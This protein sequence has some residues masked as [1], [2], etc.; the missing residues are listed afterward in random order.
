MMARTISSIL[1]LMGILVGVP[2]TGQDD[3][4]TAN[5]YARWENGPSAGDD[6]FPIAVWL[7]NP[8]NASRYRQ[9]GINLYIESPDG[10]NVMLTLRGSDASN[11]VELVGV[12][13]KMEVRDGKLGLHLE[14]YGFQLLRFPLR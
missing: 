2:A 5:G 4:A 13:Q 12:D 9:A 1:I 11:Q 7:Q 10:T 6:Y 8:S 3:S 14:G